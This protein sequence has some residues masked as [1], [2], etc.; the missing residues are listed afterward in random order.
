LTAFQ[1]CPAFLDWKCGKLL[2]FLLC[3][4]INNNDHEP[5]YHKS[6]SVHRFNNN[7]LAVEKTTNT[8]SLEFLRT[9]LFLTLAPGIKSMLKEG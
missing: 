6:L 9:S 1:K 3:W 8:Y 4:K 5:V 7:F 2:I